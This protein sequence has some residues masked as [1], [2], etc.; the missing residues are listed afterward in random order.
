MSPY[1]SLA[2][3]TAS[4]PPDGGSATP[5]K[6]VALVGFSN[7]GKTTLICKLLSLAAERSF[8]VAAVKHSHKMLEVDPSGK[9]T[10]RFRQAGACTVALAAPGLLQVTHFSGEDLAAEKVLAAL[11]R[12]SDFILVEGY[13][14]GPLPKIIF[15]PAGTPE[16]ALP[17]F[18]NGIA[19]ISEHAL[20]TDLPVFSRNQVEA[21]LNFILQWLRI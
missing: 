6:A 15:V 7:C 12:D 14:H 1:S 21:I 10:W 3:K 16:A 4:S 13:K 20:T 17:P 11:P 18:P 9:D 19:Y 2:D 5:V 8:R